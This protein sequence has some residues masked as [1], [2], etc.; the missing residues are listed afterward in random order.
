MPQLG[1]L[2]L[3]DD[4]R[5]AQL[6]TTLGFV[7]KLYLGGSFNETKQDIRTGDGFVEVG[8]ENGVGLR[9]DLENGDADG[10]N[11]YRFRWQYPPSTLHLDYLKVG[12]GWKFATSV[13]FSH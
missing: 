9:V 5:S 4:G 1:Q 10:L 7:L 6:I 11:I 13:I 8:Y 2:Q 3:A 12:E